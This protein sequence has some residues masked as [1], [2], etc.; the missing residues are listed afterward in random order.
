MAY[1]TVPIQG[2][3]EFTIRFVIW[4]TGDFRFDSTVLIDNFRWVDDPVDLVTAP[5]F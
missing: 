5:T 4:D 1:T 3:E 2:G